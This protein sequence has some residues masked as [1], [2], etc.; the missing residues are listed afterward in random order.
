MP[1]AR[2]PRPAP[3]PAPARA[4][5][6]RMYNVG[7]GD[8]VLFFIPCADGE[9]TVLVDCG[10]HMSGVARPMSAVTKDLVAT[11]TREG[12]PR[13]DVV[14]AT[15]RHFDH[16]SGFDSKIWSGVEVGEIWMPWTEERGAPAADALRHRQK[17]IAAMLHQRFGADDTSVGWLSRNSFSNRNAEQTLLNGFVGPREHRYLPAPD[18]KE[19]TF[20][21]AL[22]PGVKV[23]GLG[24]SHDPD[25]IA[26]LDPPEGK[27]FPPPPEQ[28]GPMGAA[29]D[30]ATVA[31][32]EARIFSDRWR[33]SPAE[34]GASFTSLADHASSDEIRR[35]A[36]TDYLAAAASLEDAI[37]GT[38]LVLALEIDDRVVL[39]GGDA[40]WGTWREIL[41]DDAWSNLLR[42]TLIY[43]VSHHGSFNGTPKPFVDDLLPADAISLMSFRPVKR[44][45]SIPR[46]TLVDALGSGN[47]AL[48]RTDAMPP[49]SPTIARN[50]D[51]WVEVSVPLV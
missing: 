14:V 44:W 8:C 17:R 46:T 48:I 37:N 21:T 22:L 26:T 39:L 40:E 23:H 6:A 13:I 50:G 51:L 35:R 32:P 24:P 38:S 20:Q 18:R 31:A 16:I 30:V 25:V 47:R 3:A 28:R 7:F 42:R 9:R 34:Y 5:R 45:P 41:A 10:A 27:Y 2:R 15:H 29:A 4:L 36:E 43:K 49:A 1:A 12:R 11:V 33:L 19:R